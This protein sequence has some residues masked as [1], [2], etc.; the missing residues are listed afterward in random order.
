MSS[1]KD[2]SAG[3]LV[4]DL[5]SYGQQISSDFSITIDHSPGNDLFI[6][7]WYPSGNPELKDVLNYTRLMQHED[8]LTYEDWLYEAREDIKNIAR[9]LEEGVFWP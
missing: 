1:T 4:D 7:R 2:V 6:L 8:Y 3:K 9:Q 5:V